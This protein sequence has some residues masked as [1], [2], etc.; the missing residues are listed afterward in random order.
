[1][2]LSVSMGQSH[3]H[4]YMQ[5]FKRN[6]VCNVSVLCVCVGENEWEGLK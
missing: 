4:A 5:A 6:T 2:P 3:L 1:M